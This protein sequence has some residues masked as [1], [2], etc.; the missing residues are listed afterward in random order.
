MRG[1]RPHRSAHR[2]PVAGA[3]RLLLAG[4][5]GMGAA[6]LVACGSSGSG[7]IPFRNAGP[8]EADF[9]A[10]AQAAQEGGGS[11]T[12]TEAAIQKAEHDLHVLPSTVDGGL[13][14]R[15][16][17]GISSLSA[18]ARE[19]CAQASTTTPASTSTTRTTPPAT[20][21]S[22]QPTQTTSTQATTPTSTA[23][24]QT[25]S[26]PTGTEGGGTPAEGAGQAPGVGAGEGQAGE[27]GA[28][29][30]AAGSG[31]AGPGAREG[32]ASGGATGGT[33]GGQ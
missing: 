28:G 8:L 21:T 6:A 26:Q 17:E 23:P 5:L 31:A 7:L 11:C 22:T 3:L 27:A 16:E 10:I 14:G 20:T 24:A 32:G 12:A 9:Q 29:N 19:L 18:R 25:T 13:R 4:L 15:L 1:P 30:G 33:G 2:G